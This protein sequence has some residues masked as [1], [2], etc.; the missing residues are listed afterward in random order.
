MPNYIVPGGGGSGGGSGARGPT[1][2]SIRRVYRT[3]GEGLAAD[4]VPAWEN[5]LELGQSPN[6]EERGWRAS[7]FGL[8]QGRFSIGTFLA[9]WRSLL[10]G[11]QV[12]SLFW[13]SEAGNA[14]NGFIRIELHVQS[15][16]LQQN[17]DVL[18]ALHVAAPTAR[19]RV[20][21]GSNSYD[22]IP[23]PVENANRI[24]APSGRFFYFRT[25]AA[26]DIAD[27][28]A[29]YAND[30][31]VSTRIQIIRETTA[32]RVADVTVGTQD[33]NWLDYLE[34]AVPVEF[35]ELPD[36]PADGSNDR[37]F[38]ATAPYRE[39]HRIGPWI[40]A[41]LTGFDGEDGT[42]GVSGSAAALP[43]NILVDSPRWA[44]K[45]NFI[46]TSLTD[47][48]DVNFS[49][50]TAGGFLAPIGIAEADIPTYPYDDGRH[51]VP[52]NWHDGNDFVTIP[53][54]IL[55][56]SC[57]I[58]MEL[59][60]ENESRRV[61]AANVDQERN[62][63]S[64][65]IVHYFQNDA[66]EYQ[67]IAINTRYSIPGGNAIPTDTGTSLLLTNAMVSEING[68]R[69]WRIQSRFGYS[70]LPINENSETQNAPILVYSL[71]VSPNTPQRNLNDQTGAYPSGDTYTGLEIP[72][73]GA[74]TAE[75]NQGDGQQAPDGFVPANQEG[76]APGLGDAAIPGADTTFQS[77]YR[78]ASFDLQNRNNVAIAEI[79]GTTLQLNSQAVV[80]WRRTDTDSWNTFSMA[81]PVGGG[82]AGPFRSDPI[83]L[84]SAH[85]TTPSSTTIELGLRSVSSAG[86]HANGIEAQYT[87]YR[88]AET[89]G[90]TRSIVL[91]EQVLFA[92]AGVQVVLQFDEP[93]DLNLI[94]GIYL[95]LTRADASSW[96]S[97]ISVAEIRALMHDGGNDVS[98]LPVAITSIGE[99]TLQVY[100]TEEGGQLLWY[101]G[102]ADNDHVT[103]AAFNFLSTDGDGAPRVTGMHS[104]RSRGFGNFQ[105]AVHHR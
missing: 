89:A 98:A 67:R 46:N 85:T 14:N 19:V 105:I 25:D 30:D 65:L 92:D 53:Q 51:Y 40:V 42:D 48:R 64:Y 75:A 79:A 93:L 37:I 73:P 1:G 102:A 27:P 4:S 7:S 97:F 63:S 5:N 58:R 69:A 103:R 36:L 96:T 12:R 87:L 29:D 99:N 6:M 16:E 44:R 91:Q 11:V 47:P 50:F 35:T 18:Q 54:N 22:L 61:N 76:V 66:G 20:W 15:A 26:T 100:K 94:H 77:I 62:G 68:V 95:V 31:L 57:Y 9:D 72:P 55:G 13:D 71:A 17:V 34:P 24:A 82:A 28:F 43:V 101:R 59:A 38:S 23:D 70:F 21:F 39:I 32:T 84:S 86:F 2:D 56:S 41:P 8:L 33:V 45:S 52:L 80:V 10:G 90:V 81:V 78:I 88:P 104:I 74:Q 83:E 49:D 3:G 60:F